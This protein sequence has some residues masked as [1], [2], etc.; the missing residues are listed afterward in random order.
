MSLGRDLSSRGREPRCL[1]RLGVDD[2]GLGVLKKSLGSFLE[3][4]II[5]SGVLLFDITG[6]SGITLIFDSL[7]IPTLLYLTATQ[8]YKPVDCCGLRVSLRETIVF[9]FAVNWQSTFF[10]GF[11]C[12]P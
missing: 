8:R 3:L 5:V 11:S 9:N 6:S 1:S 4:I 10:I 12:T 2:V 7:T